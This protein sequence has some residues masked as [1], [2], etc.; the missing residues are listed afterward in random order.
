MILNRRRCLRCDRINQ[1]FPM[2]ASD[3]HRKDLA[4]DLPYMG[5]TVSQAYEMQLGGPFHVSEQ[6]YQEYRRSMGEHGSA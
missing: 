6:A 4:K 1:R 2:A 5:P 3:Q